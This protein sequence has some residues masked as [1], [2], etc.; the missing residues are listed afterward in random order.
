MPRGEWLATGT[1]AH[2]HMW[3]VTTA[4]FLDVRAEDLPPIPIPPIP[5]ILLQYSSNTLQ[6]PPIPPI[7]PSYLFCLFTSAIATATI[8]C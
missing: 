4:P 6:Y 5:P 8:S 2:I 3:L 1:V 7:P